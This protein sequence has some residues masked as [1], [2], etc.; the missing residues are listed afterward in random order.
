MSKILKD[1]G[2]KED[3][4]LTTVKSDEIQTDHIK[5]IQKNT[6][7][8]KIVYKTKYSLLDIIQ[9]LKEPLITNNKH[10]NGLWMFGDCSDVNLGSQTDNITYKGKFFMIDYDNGYTIEQ[11]EEDY[12]DYFYL[13]YTSF[14]HTNEHHK[15]RVIMFGNWENPMNV[16]TQN[17]IL[18]E[19]FRNADKTTL[20]PNRLFYLPAHKPNSPYVYKQHYGKQF[21]LDNTV[22][23]YLI[24]KQQVDRAKEL[25]QDKAWADYTHTKDHNGMC[26]EYST[27]KHYLETSYP[28]ITGNGDS[29]ISLFKAIRCCLKYGDNQ[30]LDDV[31]FKA[32]NE[33]WTQKELDH[34]INDARKKI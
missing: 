16:D 10:E 29:S 17:I 8:D 11:F 20:Q 24:T 18:S 33:H 12:K 31:L 30:T 9:T 2:L 5:V 15:F 23:R 28:N 3:M 6:R 25:E 1:F 34:K 26:R 22:V 7:F 21:P 4:D 27:V 19:C 13:L 14:S 32:R